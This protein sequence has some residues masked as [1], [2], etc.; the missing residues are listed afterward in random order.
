MFRSLRF[1]LGAIFVGFLLLV[2]GGAIATSTAVQ[3]QTHDAT[4]I[5]L[6]GRQRMLTQQMTWLALAQP[7][8]PELEI[9]IAHFDQTLRALRDGGTAPGVANRLVTLPPAPDA[10]LHAKLDQVTTTWRSFQTHLDDLATLPASSPQHQE[11]ERALQE[12]SRLI[13]AQLDTIVSAF[14]AQAQAKVAQL[15]QIQ[16][17]FLALALLLLA[18]GYFTIR[19]R[20]VLPLGTLAAAT[21][22]MGKG[23]LQT[24]VSTESHDELGQLAQ[25]FETMR[26]QLAA[27]QQTLHSRV[28]QRTRELATAFE[29]SQEI[30]SQLELDSL[31]RSVVA[32]ARDLMQAQAASLCLLTPDGRHL[33]LVASSGETAVETGLKQST[34]RAIAA[35]VIEVGRTVMTATGCANCGFLHAHTPGLCVAAPLRVR[36]E[37]LG[38]LCVVRAHDRTAAENVPFDADEQR[39]LTLLANSAAIAIANARLAEAERHKA[40]Q[41]AVLAERQRLAADLHDNLAQT[42]SFLRLKTERAEEMV[43]GGHTEAALAHLERMWAAAETAY[44]QVRAALV[45]LHEE[46]PDGND[47]ARKLTSCVETFRET[48]AVEVQLS[49]GD[50]A[51]LELPRVVQTQVLHI[52]KEALTNVR[53]HAQA[54]RVEVRVD[55]INGMARFGVQDDGCGFDPAAVAAGDHHLGLTIMRT[56]AERSGGH[57][58][59]ESAPGAGTT[60]TATFSL[61]ETAGNRPGTKKIERKNNHESQAYP[62]G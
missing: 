17:V 23:D 11:A 28:A 10:G 62:I 15:Q 56:R 61:A 57:L 48:A 14:E 38:A 39:A 35:D 43:T 52:I 1:Q 24:A 33:E 45:D 55:R 41:A 18:G 19:Q 7:R 25:A 27:S 59:V 6:A 8:S 58:N 46:P 49:I 42:L 40:E 12:E 3:A 20:L 44:G 4:V 50:V 31:L 32:R 16:I 29:F 36:D 54:Q 60:V 37:T 21:R 34:N 22:R 5:N 30:V 13:L 47:L 2:V 9:A 26:A 53:R 51:A